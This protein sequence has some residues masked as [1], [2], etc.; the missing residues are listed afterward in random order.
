MLFIELCDLCPEICLSGFKLQ[1]SMEILAD[2][3]LIQSVDLEL[4]AG[5]SLKTELF[6]MKSQFG[7]MAS[8][9]A[10]NLFLKLLLPRI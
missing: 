7:F 5:P 4:H 8:S 10:V 1:R 9:L 2:F 3:S 6:V